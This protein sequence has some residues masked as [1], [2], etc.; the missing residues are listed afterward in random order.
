MP[1]QRYYFIFFILHNLFFI[2]DTWYKIEYHSCKNNIF[3]VYFIWFCFLF[4][5]GRRCRSYKR[6]FYRNE[7]T[8]GIQWEYPTTQTTDEV[9]VQGGE[10][11]MELCDSPPPPQPPPPPPPVSPPPPPPPPRIS[12]RSPSPDTGNHRACRL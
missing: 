5:F 10:E 7:E 1:L 12:S 8:G 3:G 11:A 9:Q 2:I 6:Y 4:M